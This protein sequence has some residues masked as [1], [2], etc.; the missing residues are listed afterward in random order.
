MN[1]VRSATAGIAVRTRSSRLRNAVGGAF[2]LHRPQ[3]RVIGMLQRHIYILNHF[4]RLAMAASNSS[5][6][7]F[8]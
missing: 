5:V 8:G 4:W 3:H 2:A 6:T 1:E 7:K